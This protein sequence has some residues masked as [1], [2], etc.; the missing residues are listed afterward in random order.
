MI[1][2]DALLLLLVANGAPIIARELTRDRWDRP[3]DF[4]LRVADGR[5]LFGPAKT[6]RGVFASLLFTAVFAPLLS[7]S[8]QLGLAMGAAA[9]LG[10]LLS[11]FTKR[12]LGIV[13]SGRATGLDQAP[14]ALLPLLVLHLQAPMSWGQVI[15]ATLLFTGGG[16][17][18]SRLLYRLHVRRRPY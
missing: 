6:W 3:V 14:E 5:D 9:M 17:L 16:L 8:W 11:S 2:V 1:L 10:D 12:R 4:G 15:L 7:Y 13:S 18:L